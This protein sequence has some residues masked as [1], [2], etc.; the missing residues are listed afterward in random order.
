MQEAHMKLP[1]LV[2]PLLSKIP[3][4]NNFR[5][6][7][8]ENVAYCMRYHVEPKGKVLFWEGDPPGLCYLILSG[9]VSVW[10]RSADPKKQFESPDEEP[11]LITAEHD[12][13][14][15]CENVCDGLAA[16][17]KPLNINDL[18][19]KAKAAE[20]KA[21]EVEEE[22]IT[23][24]KMRKRAS[25]GSTVAIQTLFG[26]QV[27]CIGSGIVF[28]EE[29]LMNDAPRN[30]TVTCEEATRLL[31]ISRSDFDRVVKQ[32]LIKVKLKALSSQ[33]RRLLREF[34]LFKELSS[35]VQDSLA[36]IIH[37]I[38]APAGALLF[39][40][41]D[42]PNLCY[43]CL[44]GEV[45]VWDNGNSW[46]PR[47]KE[48]INSS[49]LRAETRTELADIEDLNHGS[50][51][52]NLIYRQ[53]IRPCL[54]S[55]S[56]LARE[57]CAAL[58]SI[59]TGVCGL[60][61]SIGHEDQFEDD[62]IV[63]SQSEAVAALGPGTLFGEL[64]LLNDNPR[65]ATVSCYKNSEFLVIEKDD[66]D[67]LLKSELN[68]AKEEKLDF[69]R[70]HVPGVRALPLA[71]SERLLYY[72]NKETVPKN[73]A[74][75]EQGAMLHGDIYFV[76]QG[77]VESYTL[78]PN[79]GLRRRGILLRGSVFAAVPANTMSTF[80]VVATTSPCEVLHLRPEFR[81]QIPDIVMH[82]IKES[83][84]LTFARRDGQCKPLERMS[85]E[86]SPMTFLKPQKASRQKERHPRRTC[87][88]P[89]AKKLFQRVN[90]EIDHEVFEMTP[91][92]TIA[93]TGSKVKRR[94]G[95][96][97]GLHE[98]MS[99]PQLRPWSSQ[100]HSSLCSL[101]ALS[102]ANKSLTKILHVELEN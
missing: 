3:F 28:G 16:M 61:Q 98:S 94:P 40:Q 79:G 60:M 46:S 25:R 41:G 63:K 45:T 42:S 1:G 17:D 43:I 47:E 10:K 83:I 91:G 55:A 84:E 29:A 75:I 68:R 76:W 57:K 12:V 5:E 7:V 101:S 8:L 88:V 30:A 96:R 4:F 66:F 22:N 35:G 65:N 18:I 86:T 85:F 26:T 31:C 80:T 70:T 24:A 69:L 89:D 15:H 33:I 9:V 19:T 67:R 78:L 77:S 21:Q 52:L 92:E 99:A 71:P 13:L 2:E 14:Q 37:Y 59:L 53:Q 102:P 48:K 72:F 32:D 82:S 50:K 62:A 97:P 11:E 56:A 73:H 81:K 36:D 95:S 23:Q 90:A 49:R 38:R 20:K 87:L 93:M 6:S 54:E 100:S 34:D 27:A 74:F 51:A 39:E 58:A 64:A 44:S